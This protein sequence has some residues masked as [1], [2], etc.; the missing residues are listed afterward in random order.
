MR[1]ARAGRFRSEML[2]AYIMNDPRVTVR[3]FVVENFLFGQ[4]DDLRDEDS[5]L[6]KGVLDSTGV[7]ELVAFL[8]KQFSIKIGDTELVP[9][10]LD[11]VNV[12]CE[13]IA[14]KNADK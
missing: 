7:M 13:F 14:R 2:H 3:Q 12:I 4:G 9:D 1:P 6:E 11:S 8:E 5:F 10:N